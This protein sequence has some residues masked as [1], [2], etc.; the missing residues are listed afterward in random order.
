VFSHWPAW[1]LPRSLRLYDIE[2]ESCGYFAGR[3]TRFLYHV[4]PR[5]SPR[6]YH[7]LMDAGFR[8]SGQVMYQPNCP[9]CRDCVPV[10]VPVDEFA[11]DKSQRRNWKRNQDLRITIDRPRLTQEK[12]DLY[13]RYQEARHGQSRDE[14]AKGLAE[15]LYHSPVATFEF[16]YRNAAD[17]LLAVGIADVCEL[18]VSSVY[19]YYDPD[20]RKRGLGVFGAMVEIDA[21]RRRGIPYYYLGFWVRGCDRMAYKRDFRPAELLGTDGVWRRAPRAVIEPRRED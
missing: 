11:P 19:F 3:R 16:C 6:E 10:R 18:S 13:C 2:G 8:R 7:E 14:A 20:E 15:F 4:A 9:G 1:P 21:C 12:V 5:M 17:R